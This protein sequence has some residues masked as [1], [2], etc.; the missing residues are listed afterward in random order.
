MI[1][2]DSYYFYAMFI[3]IIIL[4]VI[5]NSAIPIG[6]IVVISLIGRVL[7]KFKIITH[8]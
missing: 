6:G 1:D 2:E 5:F 8:E 7:I 3:F 4:S